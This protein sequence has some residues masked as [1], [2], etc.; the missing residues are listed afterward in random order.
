MLIFSN[1]ILPLINASIEIDARHTIIKR[2]LKGYLKPF[3]NKLQT[4]YKIGNADK[5]ERT[6][7]ALYSC[8]EFVMRFNSRHNLFFEEYKILM[9]G[10]ESKQNCQIGNQYCP[11]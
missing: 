6:N 2:V 5:I 3:L 11:Q 9:S 10:K 1:F 4:Y 7:F 8:N